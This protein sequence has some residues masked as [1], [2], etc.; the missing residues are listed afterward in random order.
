MG[1]ESYASVGQLYLQ[2]PAVVNKHGCNT[3]HPFR[4]WNGHYVSVHNGLLWYANYSALFCTHIAVSLCDT[5]KYLL[6][7]LG[8]LP[9]HV[10]LAWHVL[11]LG[12]VRL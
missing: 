12:P 8:P 9:D 3:F 4:K 7:Q 2:T 11:V 10:P 1:R 5:E 6:S